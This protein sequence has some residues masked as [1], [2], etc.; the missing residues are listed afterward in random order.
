MIVTMLTMMHVCVRVKAD[1]V[2]VV[3]RVTGNEALKRVTAIGD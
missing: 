3:R 1:K 2:T